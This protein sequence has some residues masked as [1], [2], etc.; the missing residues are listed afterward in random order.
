MTNKSNWLSGCLC[1]G[2]AVEIVIA[3]VLR[4][5]LA[6]RMLQGDAAGM[7]L[8][9]LVGLLWLP[10]LGVI[11]WAVMSRVRIL[12]SG[13][14]DR[15]GQLTALAS[16]SYDW[17]WQTGT[18]LRLVVSSPA[19]FALRGHRPEDLVGRSML[20]LVHVDDAAALRAMVSDAT[21]HDRGWIEAELHWVHATGR[22]VTLQGRA[23]SIL[24]AS[25]RAIGYRGAWRPAPVESADQLRLSGVA[26]RTRDLI[27]TRSLKVALQ[28]IIDLDTGT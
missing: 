9:A 18:D 22:V 21:A 7:N 11:P 16:T 13:L 25:G 10:V 20:D 28:P 5:P 24:D 15:D 19:S 12:D 3:L 2:L 8:V 26:H 6:L 17:L 27:G 14:H 23:C 1:V 4:G